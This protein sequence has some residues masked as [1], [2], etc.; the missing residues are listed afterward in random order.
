VKKEYKKFWTQDLTNLHIDWD[1]EKLYFFVKEGEDFYPPKMRSKGKQW[2]L[3]FYIR[4]SARSKDNSS[5]I[6]LID[7]PGLF[8]HATAQ[9]D[10]LK[11]LEDSSKNTQIIFSTHSPYL[12]EPNKWHRLRLLFKNDKIGTIIENKIHKISDKETLTPILTAIGLEL[13]SGITNLDKVN[14]VIVEGP[15]D[16]YYLQ[17][18]KNILKKNN[19]NFVFGGG[20]GNMPFVGTILSGWGCHVL[21]LYD[22]DQGKRDAEKN[23]KKNWL[24]STEEIIAITDRKGESV[25]DIFIKDDFKKYVLQNEQ[26]EY[27]C[28]NSEYLKRIKKDKVLL[29]KLFFEN[30]RENALSSETKKK[31]EQIFEIIE[32]K[33]KSEF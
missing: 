22:N 19:I 25:E 27:E 15:S 2:H 4:V 18:F 3:A 9:R 8:V 32:N 11:K 24:I 21:Y 1:S 6:I 33:F 14:N 17:A 16:W 29:S 31:I 28:K 7:E 10:I 5:N 23:L 12:I 13:S 30:W 20:A 26:L